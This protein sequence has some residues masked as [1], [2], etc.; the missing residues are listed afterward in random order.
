LFRSPQGVSTLAVKSGAM[1]RVITSACIGTKSMDCVEVCPVDCIHP[2]KDNPDNPNQ[3]QLFID[4]ATCIDCGACEPAC[5]VSAIF[6]EDDVPD[7][8]K[9]YIQINADY[10]K[11]SAAA[12]PA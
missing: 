6:P 9:Q 5:P 8:Q 2:K 4:P 12:T 11:K 10:F 7:D 3:K 1:T